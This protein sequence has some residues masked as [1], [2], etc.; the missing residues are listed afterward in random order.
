[1]K[2]NKYIVVFNAEA[3]GLGTE[4]GGAYGKSTTS[5][6]VDN[7]DNQGA[8]VAVSELN[9]LVYGELA[10]PEYYRWKRTA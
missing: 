4:I 8:A 5:F 7:A 9:I 2:N 10:T 3:S 1:M 6:K